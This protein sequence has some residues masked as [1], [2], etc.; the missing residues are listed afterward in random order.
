MSPSFCRPASTLLALSSLSL[1]ILTGCGANTTSYSGPTP[2]SKISGKVFGGQQP[3]Y[4][5]QV[6]V[7]SIGLTT[8]GSP[9]TPLAITYTDTDGSFSFS[10]SAYE[11]ATPTTQVYITAQGGNATEQNGDSTTGYVNPSIALATGLGDCSSAQTAS[12]E[13]NEVTTAATAYALAQFFTTTLGATDDF[14]TDP[15]DLTSFTLSNTATIPLLVDTKHGTANTT[16][17]SITLESAKL[18]SIA[19]TLAACVNDTAAPTLPPPDPLTD[20]CQVLFADTTPPG[21]TTAPTDTL[22]AAVQM[23]LYPA[24]NV[25]DLWKLGSKTAAFVGLPQAP[26]DWTLGVSYTSSAFGLGISTYSGLASSA[27]ID[28]DTNGRIWFP[29]NSGASVLAE[30]PGGIAYFDPATTSFNGPYLNGSYPAPDGSITPDFSFVQPQYVAIDGAGL[31]W[32]TDQGASFG[33]Y[34][35]VDTGSIDNMTPGSSPTPY[36]LGLLAYLGPIASD[37]SGNVFFSGDIVFGDTGVFLY[38]ASSGEAVGAWE[39]SPTGIVAASAIPGST[40]NAANDFI[41]ASTSA[42]TSSTDT[43]C[44]IENLDNGPYE[45][46]ASPCSSGGIA[47][48]YE[49]EAVVTAATTLNQYCLDGDLGVVTPGCTAPSATASQV[50]LPE[51]LATDGRDNLWA[52]MSGNSSVFVGGLYPDNATQFTADYVHDSSNGNTMTTPYA[53]AIDGS[54]NVWIANAGCVAT[55]A[56]SGGCAPGPFVLSELIGAAG[57]TITPLSAQMVDAGYF[58]GHTPGT[59]APGGCRRGPGGTPLRRNRSTPATIFDPRC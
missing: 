43:P 23:A 37:G 1:I 29:T 57:P 26:A 20:P 6:T 33:T 8:Y 38:S 34:G 42:T 13:I 27:T 56:A 44:L 36:N 39:L 4:N 49:A 10:D 18:Y 50:S 31:A 46:S 5:S 28:I 21:G 12:V 51:G 53:I 19:N 55:L 35:S 24:Q 3:I 32:L 59:P 52:A 16:T 7:W 54:G 25:S 48:E 14:G 45:T 47:F 22:Q 41:L 58:I 9:A 40:S 2:S 17:S 30:T 11:C 15:A